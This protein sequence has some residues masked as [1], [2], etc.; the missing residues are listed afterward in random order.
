MLY[1]S[2]PPLLALCFSLVSATGCVSTEKSDPN[3]LPELDVQD[4]DPEKDKGGPQFCNPTGKSG[5]ELKKCYEHNEQIYGE[6][7]AEAKQREPWFNFT[8]ESWVTS[9]ELDPKFI[10]NVTQEAEAVKKLETAPFV[11]LSASDVQHYTGKAA[12][13]PGAKPYLLRGLI[14]FKD[15]GSFSVFEKDESVYVRHDSL[16]SSTPKE[17]R[18][19]VVVFLAFKPKTVYVDCQVAE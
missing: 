9:K 11:E 17:T 2:L 14:Y 3:A 5:D 19:A 7:D 10:F 4:P 13:F 16:G 18:S 12:S 6:F 8:P 1:R 15:T